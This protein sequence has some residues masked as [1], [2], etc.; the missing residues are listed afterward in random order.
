MLANARS[1]GHVFNPI[2]VYWCTAPGAE[3]AE[4]VVAEVHNTYGERHAYLLSPSADGRAEV[5]KELYVSPFYPVNGRYRMRLS[6][7]GERMSVA[8]TYEPDGASPF[9][10]TLT[11]QRRPFSTGSLVRLLL[12]YPSASLRVSTLIR[13]QGV[14]LWLR[15]LRPVRRPVHRP[16]EGVQ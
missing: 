11:G 4:H 1:L 13:I 9:V 16:Q 2:T 7:P 12:R 15:G 14:R 5:D 3:R 6:E 10:A 8:I